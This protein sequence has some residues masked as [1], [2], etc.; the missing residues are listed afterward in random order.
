MQQKLLSLEEFLLQSYDRE[1]AFSAK[2]LVQVCTDERKSFA[3]RG[4]LNVRG[5]GGN[6][7]SGAVVRK[8]LTTSQ[9]RDAAETSKTRPVEEAKLNR[10]L[11][12]NNLRV[13]VISTVSQ[14][15]S[16]Q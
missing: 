3:R 5:S 6:T 12:K 1:R 11:P 4:N 10:R 15:C 7:S 16:E 2:E 9:V 14:S 13:A 8:M